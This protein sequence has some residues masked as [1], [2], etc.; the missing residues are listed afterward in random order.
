MPAMSTCSSRRTV[1]WSRARLG[2]MGAFPISLISSASEGV[3]ARDAGSP[4]QRPCCS[5]S[6][7][8]PAV[9]SG[10]IAPLFPLRNQRIALLY[11][12]LE[13]LILLREAVGVA[14]FV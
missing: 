2:K 14:L 3:A 7:L 1:K 12:P 6:P 4:S 9:G 5:P 11:Q 13:F 10:R 8:A